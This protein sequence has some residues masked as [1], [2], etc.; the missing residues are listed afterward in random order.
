MLQTRTGLGFSPW[1]ADIGTPIHAPD[2]FDLEARIKA[3]LS[4]DLENESLDAS[5][6]AGAPDQPS[7]DAAQACDPDEPALED[8]ESMDTSVP[9]LDH[10]F[11]GFAR[12]DDA[13]VSSSAESQSTSKKKAHS[14]KHAR[15]HWNNQ[16]QRRVLPGVLGTSS[17][18]LKQAALKKLLAAVALHTNADTEAAIAR[19][20]AAFPARPDV[21][22]IETDL[23]LDMNDVPVASSAFNRSTHQADRCRSCPSGRGRT[24][25]GRW[26]E[27]QGLGW[28]VS[29]VKCSRL[30]FTF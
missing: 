14:R 10:L 16:R 19:D 4:G 24:E 20:D 25:E 7:L 21:T 1:T 29:S 5:L 27:I 30:L 3:A 12:V 9:S 15:E 6:P 18:P 11:D 2:D 22:P 28:E 17:K 8:A 23:S 26:M 13:P